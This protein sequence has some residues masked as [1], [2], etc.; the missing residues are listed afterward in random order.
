[1]YVLISLRWIALVLGLLAACRLAGP[2]MA[3]RADSFE[4]SGT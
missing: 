4:V 2:V 3:A 1:M